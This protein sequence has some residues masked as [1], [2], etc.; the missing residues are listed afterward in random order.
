MSSNLKASSSSSSSSSCCCSGGGGGS[1]SSSSSK[2]HLSHFTV[3]II[4]KYTALFH[5]MMT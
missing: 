3:E 2:F 4:T 1:S 5:C